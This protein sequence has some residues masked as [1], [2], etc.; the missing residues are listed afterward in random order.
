MDYFNKPMSNIKN[1]TANWYIDFFA[2]YYLRFFGHKKTPLDTKR[3]VEFIYHTLNLARGAKILDLASGPG[4]HAIELAK[5]GFN[6]TCLDLNKQ[7]LDLTQKLAKQN[8]VSLRMVQSDM[9]IIPYKNEFDVVINMFSSFGYFDKEK[10]NFK[11][12]KAVS[13]ALKLN[14]LFLLDL[15]NKNWLL[16]KVPKKTWQ[17]INNKYIL[18]ERSFDK[19]RKIYL[20]NITIITPDKKIKHTSTLMRLY[21]LFEIRRKLNYAGFK[22]IKVYGDYKDEKFIKEISPRMIIL[23]R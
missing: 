15:P 7:F 12:L 23:A 6:V 13:N 8:N 21:D 4:R 5:R 19:K 22:V 20:D 11:V 14:G 3:E 18:E 9:R 17:K 16:T 10:E 1:K 2:K